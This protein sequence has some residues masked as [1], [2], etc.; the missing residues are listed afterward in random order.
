MVVRGYIKVLVTT[1]FDRLLETALRARGIDPVVTTCDADLSRMTQREHAHCFVLKPHGDYQQMTIRNTTLELAK[2]EPGLTKELKTIVDRYGLVVLG[3]SGADEAIASIV[4]RRRSHYGLWWVSRGDPQPIAAALIE[5][6]AGRVV[7][8]DCAEDFLRD[9]LSRV[10]V[11]EMHP[12]GLVPGMVHDELV[13]LL[14][15][16]DDVGVETFLRQERA[17]FAEVL[18]YASKLPLHAATNK[19]AGAAV[20]AALMPSMER[21]L[22]GLVPLALLDAGRFGEEMTFLTDTISRQRLRSGNTAFLHVPQW[23]AW[24]LSYVVG[25]LALAER[26]WSAVETILRSTFVDTFDKARFIM[27]SAGETGRALGALVNGKEW[28][29]PEWMFMVKTLGE[30]TWL[31]ERYPT[32]VDPSDEPARTLAEFSLIAGVAMRLRGVQITA[33]WDMYND[34]SRRFAIRIYHDERLRDQVA[35]A[36][37]MVESMNFASD[38]SAALG[39]GYFPLG[40]Q[41]TDLNAL[42]ATGRD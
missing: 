34:C 8:R 39:K 37:G 30:M 16:H 2:L 5:A 25:G 40:Y 42:L 24:F 23:S 21:R 7:R 9:L 18:D 1:N 12:T 28:L 38:A 3:Y 11:Y 17:A 29:S 19:E 15:R 6:S 20:H 32:F 27:A 41:Q 4:R 13:A 10:E 26:K 33:Y 22:A 35:S 36:V 14:R 31:R